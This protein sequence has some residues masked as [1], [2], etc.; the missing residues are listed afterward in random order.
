[1]KKKLLSVAGGVLALVA[2]YF[3]MPG[4]VSRVAPVANQA[5]GALAGPD[6][7]S[8]YLRWGGVAEYHAQEALQATSTMVC[9]TQSPAATSTLLGFS[10]LVDSVGTI[11]SS[12]V[13]DI[14]TSTNQFST[15][16]NVFA[17]SVPFTQRPYVLDIGATTTDSR[18]IKWHAW[19]G[20]SMN[21][22]APNTWVNVKLGTT[23][24]ATTYPTGTCSW[25]FGSL[26]N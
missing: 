5:F 24:P 11:P 22:L 17:A 6:I 15:T 16:S 13:F 9:A 3:V 21:I 12:V 25:R 26:V 4:V 20:T 2:L 18:V 19:D 7:A 14:G 10:M 23:S 1:M 8:P